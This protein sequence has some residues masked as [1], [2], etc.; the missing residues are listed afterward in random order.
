M[1]LDILRGLG[2]RKK[3]PAMRTLTIREV[4]R[5]PAACTVFFDIDYVRFPHEAGQF[6]TVEDTIEGTPIRRSYSLHTWPGVD[7]YPGIL[8]RRVPSGGFSNHVNDRWRTGDLVSVLPPAGNFVL[9]ST[10]PLVLFLLAGG[11]GITPLLSLLK[12][13]LL[14][15]PRGVVHLFCANRHQEDVLLHEDMLHLSRRYKKRL[16]IIH[17]FSSTS[18]G[19]TQKKHGRIQVE[20]LV[21][22]VK[23]SAG[24]A[25]LEAHYFICGPTGLMKIIQNALATLQVP[26]VHAEYFSVPEASSPALGQDRQVCVH[27][28]GELHTFL[29]PARESIL[30]AGLRHGA[31]MPYSCMGGIC[32]ACMGRLEHGKVHMERNEALTDEERAEGFILCCQSHPTTD[33]VRIRID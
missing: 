3:S 24:K 11:S 10:L 5:Q 1:A 31:D 23:Q 14:T 17:W 7:N 13:F 32:T 26:H 21:R 33:D 16:N 12:A 30:S 4:R 19:D 18:D 9:P 8:V 15:S 28:R 22:I 27:L 6:I 25:L 2:G 20:D 29:V